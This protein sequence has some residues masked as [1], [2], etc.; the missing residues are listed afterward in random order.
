MQFDITY[1][2][3][4]PFAR[5]ANEAVMKGLEEGRDWE[6]TF[7]PFSLSQAHVKEGEGDVYE[8]TSSSGVLALHWGIAVRDSDP[9]HFPAAHVALFS[10]RHDE[11][12]DINDEA[13]IRSALDKA[14]VDSAATA[15]IVATGVPAKTLAEEHLE[16]VERWSVF[17]VPTF[18]SDEVATFIRFMERGR[19]SDVDRALDL[20]G[21]QGL[22]E[23]KR[24]RV[25]R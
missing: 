14:G 7:R 20:L 17:G 16:S 8:D 1:D 9:V 12:L 5:N 22:N 13:V 2:Y 6:V 4:C 18:I 3:L 25:P 24:T 21:W 23:F 15:E 19:V 10:A 11:G